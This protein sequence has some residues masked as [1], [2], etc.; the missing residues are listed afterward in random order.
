MCLHTWIAS[1]FCWNLDGWLENGMRDIWGCYFHPTFVVKQFQ[2]HLHL[3]YCSVA[4]FSS[5]EGIRSRDG[6]ASSLFRFKLVW[7][8]NQSGCLCLAVGFA[9]YCEHSAVQQTLGC[10]PQGA[11]KEK[12]VRP[13]MQKPGMQS[14]GLGTSALYTG[15]CQAAAVAPFFLSWVTI[16]THGS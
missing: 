1:S 11:R 8:S 16:I 6:K 12:D 7:N 4:L 2:A 9:L 10:S 3:L 13:G 5:R 15:G 14:P